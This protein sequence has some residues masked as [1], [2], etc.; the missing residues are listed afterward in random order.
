M[1]VGIYLILT[2]SIAHKKNNAK[3][4]QNGIITVKYNMLPSVKRILSLLRLLPTGFS[5]FLLL[6]CLSCEPAADLRDFADAD[7]FPPVIENLLPID[8]YR[9]I[10]Y[11]NEPV[12]ICGSPLLNPPL[13]EPVI[14]SDEYSLILEFAEQQQAGIRYTIDAEVRDKTGNR[15]SFLFPFYG[16]NPYLP[17]IIINEFTTQG[18]S[19]HPDLVEL[20]IT[21]DGN[22]AGLW[23]VEGTTDYPEQSISFPSLEVEEGDYILVHF[24]PQGIP[25]ELD[26][27]GKEQ[28][29]SEGYDVSPN[30]R[31]FWIEGG[32]GLSGN[33]GVIAVYSAPGAGVLDAV[34]YSNRTSSSD[35]K[36]SGFGSIKMLEKALQIVDEGGWVGSG[37]GGTPVPEDGI[38]PDDST[39]T[40]SICR[41]SIPEDTETKN[42]W[43]I[44]PTS[45]STFGEVNTDEIY[46]P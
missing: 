44:V 16:Y 8:E 30:A 11:F 12:E 6:A 41:A 36:Y 14:S 34:L 46:Q 31:D 10:L 40:R 26:E 24:K 43:H 13:G 19:K 1:F 7:L 23:L 17:G 29:I 37:D 5:P 18:S 32:S 20:L 21:S 39:A 38:N 25:E 4:K 33:N 45:S 27:T 15:M 28:D 2:I 3:L 35:D 42:D 9:V 22:L